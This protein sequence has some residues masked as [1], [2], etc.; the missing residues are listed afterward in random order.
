LSTYG[1]LYENLDSEVTTNIPAVDL[2]PIGV[3]L[4]AAAAAQ[5]AVQVDWWGA[6]GAVPR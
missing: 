1:L 6:G 5:K 4:D 2:Y 3:G